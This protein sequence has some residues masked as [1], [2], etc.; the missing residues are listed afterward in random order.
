M[1]NITSDTTQSLYFTLTET[2]GTASGDYPR[3]LLLPKQGTVT[4]SFDLGV[5]ISSNKMRWNQYE[6]T[7]SVT[8]GTYDYQIYSGSILLESGYCSVLSGSV[9]NIPVFEKPNQRIVFK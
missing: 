4:Q 2:L 5:D 6:F 3:V 7:G 1:L 8:G 9:A